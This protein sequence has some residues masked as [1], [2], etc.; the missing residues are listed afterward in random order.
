[1]TVIRKFLLTAACVSAIVL[2]GASAVSA[3]NYGGGTLTGPGTATPGGTMALSGTG[4][5]PNAPITITINPGGVVVTG[6]SSNGS[7]S[8]SAS[9]TAPSN[10]GTYTVSATDGVN[11]SST[12]VVVSASGGG[13]ALPVTGNSSSFPLA[14]LGATL[15]AVGALIVFGVRRS[16][17][18]NVREDVTV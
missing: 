2:G 7:G 15:L 9:V 6:I 18:K 14:Q 10:A 16:A 11:T 4:F 13:S 5:L 3:A 1:M 17:S 12:S 8:F